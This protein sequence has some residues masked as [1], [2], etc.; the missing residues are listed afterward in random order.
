M[1]ESCASLCMVMIMQVYLRPVFGCV[2]VVM[3]RLNCVTSAS[4]TIVFELCVKLC[5][6]A[7]VLM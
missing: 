4:Q 3:H 6:C 7:I 1:A 2:C 5:V